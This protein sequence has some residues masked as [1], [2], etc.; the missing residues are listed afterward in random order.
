MKQYKKPDVTISVFDGEDII[1]ASNT[2]YNNI[3]KQLTESFGVDAASI[4]SAR[5]EG[6]GDSNFD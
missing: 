4:D 6:W 5:Y 3:M 1:M 2:A